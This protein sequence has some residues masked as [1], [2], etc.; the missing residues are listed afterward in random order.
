MTVELDVC[1]S[2]CVH[3]AAVAA[4]RAAVPA[5]DALD[6]MTSMF[7]LLGDVTRVKLLFALLDVGEMCVCDLAA[8]VAV[9]ESTV[10]QSL[11]LLRT[12]G[13]VVGRREGRLVYYRLADAHVRALLDLSQ[14]HVSHPA[15]GT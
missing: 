10:S 3:P 14:E 15:G 8:T 9:S 4:A 1:A 7:R 12:A 2:P 11:R 5:G 13:V 6:S